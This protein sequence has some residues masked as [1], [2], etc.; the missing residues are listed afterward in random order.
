MKE[1]WMDGGEDRRGTCGFWNGVK[2]ESHIMATQR[3][4]CTHT[5]THSRARLGRAGAQGGERQRSE[6]VPTSRFL[7]K[8]QQ[9]KKTLNN[10]ESDCFKH[11]LVVKSLNYKTNIKF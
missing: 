7:T 6:A 10:Q 9:Q 1:R 5:Y 3:H 2:N 4:L 8:K 11:K